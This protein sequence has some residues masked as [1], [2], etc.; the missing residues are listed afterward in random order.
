MVHIM[1]QAWIAGVAALVL[2]AAA[3]GGTRTLYTTGDA[4]LNF[5]SSNTN[6]GDRT[7]LK[8]GWDEDAETP[9]GEIQNSVLLFDLTQVPPGAPIVV[10]RL[11]VYC[12]N[13]GQSGDDQYLEVSYGYLDLPWHEMQVTWNHRDEALGW[14]WTG[15][16]E[17]ERGGLS[18]VTDD[19]N[20]PVTVGPG[21]QYPDH[22]WVCFDVTDTVSEWIENGVPNYGFL[23][24]S[25]GGD[26][27]HTHVVADFD[28]RESG[29]VPYLYVEWDNTPPAPDPMSFSTPPHGISPSAIAMTAT[30]ATDTQSPPVSYYFDFVRGGS[31]GSDSSL[32]GGRDYTD[33]GLAPNTQYTYQVLAQDAVGNATAYSPE[34]SAYTWANTPMAPML[35]GPTQT[36]MKLAMNE[37]PPYGNP[38]YT[39]HAIRCIA[40]LPPDPV[41]LN[42]YVTRPG[43]HS[44][45]EEW[46]TR[47]D[48]GTV[49]VQGL[50]AGTRYTFAIKARNMEGVET[51]FG[52]G[53]SLWTQQAVAVAWG[54][55]NGDGRVT[56]ADID[57]FVAALAGYEAFQ[58]TFTAGNWF[59]ADCNCDGK[60]DFGDIDAFVACLGGHCPCQAAP[61]AP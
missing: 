12:T 60:V 23:L 41:W 38:P 6:Y 15:D 57:A 19:W 44:P 21:G 5:N 7:T 59:A 32:Q 29:T 49:L 39:L 24:W 42:Q 1:K 17:T 46:R 9:D 43:G 8:V 16:D 20:S 33:D 51:P 28:A 13:D 11:Y 53:A 52:P 47:A 61:T 26:L 22:G 10:A 2:V 36:T 25:E 35:W 37:M 27:D 34:A 50:K 40:T 58:A 55:V 14:W 48:W 56:F 31:G 4:Y 30:L 3:A 18:D 54:D 45:V